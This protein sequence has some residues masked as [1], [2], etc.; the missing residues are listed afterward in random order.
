MGWPV[1]SLRLLVLAVGFY[2]EDIEQVSVAVIQ[3]LYIG[4]NSG[5]PEFISTPIVFASLCRRGSERY[6]EWIMILL[7]IEVFK[8]ICY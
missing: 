7:F 8:L 2:V 6:L 3:V 4:Q 5:Y 1:S